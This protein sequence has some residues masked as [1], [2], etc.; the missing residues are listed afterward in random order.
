MVGDQAGGAGAGALLIAMVVGVDQLQRAAEH[1]ALIVDLVDGELH[2]L[3][4]VLAR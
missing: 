4:V 3:Q 2:R 1:A